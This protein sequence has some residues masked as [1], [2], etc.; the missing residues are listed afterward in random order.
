[1]TSPY[2]DRPLV[3]LAVSCCHPCLADPSKNCHGKTGR[4]ERPTAARSGAPRPDYAQPNGAALSL[5]RSGGWL[6][7]PG[8]RWAPL[9]GLRHEVLCS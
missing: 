9:A 4:K 8:P 3:P 5:A 2:L 7:S 1:M 6:I